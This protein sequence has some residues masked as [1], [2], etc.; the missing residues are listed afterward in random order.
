[1]VEEVK[2]DV[3]AGVEL[4]KKARAQKARVEKA[5]PGTV[6]SQADRRLKKGA[7]VWVVDED[8]LDEEAPEQVWKATVEKK[9]KEKDWWWLKFPDSGE[10]EYIHYNIFFSEEDAKISLLL[11]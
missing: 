6:G 9:S 5:K 11:E 4:Y 1:M 2:A 8:D 10:Y 3:E 7:E